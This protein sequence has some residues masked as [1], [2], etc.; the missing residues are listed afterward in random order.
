MRDRHG[1]KTKAPNRDARG[2][3]LH[4]RTASA[5]TFELLH[6]TKHTDTRKGYLLT[7]I[8]R[9]VVVVGG[10]TYLKSRNTF[11]YKINE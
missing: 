4:A 5:C 3:P 8:R 7:R 9:L 10:H 11:S 2:G 1:G 6:F